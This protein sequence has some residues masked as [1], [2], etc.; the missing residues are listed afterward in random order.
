MAEH[1]GHIMSNSLGELKKKADVGEEKRVQEGKPW[2]GL[3]DEAVVLGVCQI[4]P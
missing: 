3:D 2:G 1:D 4:R